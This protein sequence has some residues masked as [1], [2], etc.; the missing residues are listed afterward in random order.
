MT[1]ATATHATSAKHAA[2]PF[3]PPTFEVAKM[4]VP[5]EFPELSEEGLAHARDT[6]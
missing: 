6:F 2:S 1:A 5:A 4:E 3:G